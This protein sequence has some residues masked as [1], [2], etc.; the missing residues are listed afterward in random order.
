MAVAVAKSADPE[1]DALFDIFRNPAPYEWRHGID[2]LMDWCNSAAERGPA[3]RS[4][5]AITA[6]R[7]V[8]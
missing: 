3:E 4:N 8:V 2:R 7:A 6:R 1:I 5:S